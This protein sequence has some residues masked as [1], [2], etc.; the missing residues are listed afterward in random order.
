MK[1]SLAPARRTSTR[2][3]LLVTGGLVALTVAGVGGAAFAA[4]NSTTSAS[5]SVSSGTVTL[6]GIGTNAAGNRLTVAATSIAP[7]DT[8][9]RAVTLANTGTLDMASVTLTTAAGTSS[10]L[11]TDVTN[12]LQM[13][14]DKCSSTWVESAAPYTY[15]CGGTTSSVLASSPVV[16]SN[17]ALANLA[18]TSGASNNL[19][20][21]LTLPAAAGNSLQNQTSV[22]NY[23]FTGTQ[24]AAAA[25]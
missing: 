14:I 6:A 3:K 21:T 16:G 7:G 19:R 22:I 4:F 13:T 8:I 18:I 20:V 5:Q 15:T 12:G 9:Q 24:R 25:R 23:T 11:D 1:H 10:L 17:L 2:A